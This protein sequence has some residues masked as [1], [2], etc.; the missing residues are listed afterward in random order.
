MGMR[1]AMTEP[2]RSCA[3]KS[4]GV[5]VGL[6]IVSM[7]LPVLILTMAMAGC[8]K[9]G[10]PVHPGALPLPVVDR[11]EKQLDGDLLV[12]SWEVPE[13]VSFAEPD[14][15]F[16]YRSKTPAGGDCKNCP[17]IFEK[18]SDVSPSESFFGGRSDKVFYRET[19]E[20]GHVYR[21]KVR[22]YTDDGLT[23]AWSEIAE[24]SY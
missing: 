5:L 4:K 12:L 19:L 15:F 18:A 20:K 9:K 1:I 8:G 24:V 7:A 16:V 17:Y 14:G 3:T 2:V 23:G 21:Y 13:H 11:L 10:P 22:A 6:A